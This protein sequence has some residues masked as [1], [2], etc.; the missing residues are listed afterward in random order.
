MLAR[1]TCLPRRM[2]RQFEENIRLAQEMARK[3]EEERKEAIELARERAR[4]TKEKRE[5]TEAIFK[6]QREDVLAR[7]ALAR[8]RDLVRL[9]KV[10]ENNRIRAEE[11]RRRRDKAKNRIEDVSENWR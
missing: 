10:Q 8:K 1:F 4:K 6:K 5:A 7:D 11:Y 9:K 2:A 3:K